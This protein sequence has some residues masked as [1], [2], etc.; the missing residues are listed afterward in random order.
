MPKWVKCYAQHRHGDK[1]AADECNI[2]MAAKYPLQ[3]PA[4]PRTHCEVCGGSLGPFRPTQYA[5][6]VCCACPAC[7]ATGTPYDERKSP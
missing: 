4:T 7:A 3:Y 2:K 1:R 6:G 5:F